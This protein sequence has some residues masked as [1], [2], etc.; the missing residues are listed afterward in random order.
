VVYWSGQRMHMKRHGGIF[1]VAAITVA[2]LAILSVLS[3]NASHPPVTG[4]IVGHCFGW[5]NPHVEIR[6][7]SSPPP[8]SQ[9]PNSNSILRDVN[10][11]GNSWFFS[12]GYPGVWATRING[13]PAD[14]NGPGGYPNPNYGVYDLR[15]DGVS[16]GNTYTYKAK[17][18]PETP[19]SNTYSVTIN[20]AN[21]G[22]APTPTPPP[23]PTPTPPPGAGTV[24]GVC[25]WVGGA[26]EVQLTWS[27]YPPPGQGAADSNALQKGDSYPSD[28]D[29]YWG[30]L[31]NN[32]SAYSYN[33]D[34][35][36][37]NT[38]YQYRVKYRS[39]LPS[40]NTYSIYVSAEN[41]GGPPPP[42]GPLVISPTFQNVPPNVTA[43]LTVSGGTG[44]YAWSAPGGTI[45]GTGSQIGVT[46]TSDSTEAVNKT[47]TV[48]SGGQT[49]TA[50]VQVDGIATLQDSINL[51][52]PGNRRIVINDDTPV[53]EYLD[54][55]LA[56]AHGFGSVAS[57]SVLV[58]LAN[59]LEGVS[60]A[61]QQQYQQSTP[62]NLC[63]A[64]GYCNE[65]PYTV[66]AIFGAP[67]VQQSGVV[68]DN[69]VYADIFDLPPSVEINGGDTVV[70]DRMVT[71]LLE[72][73]FED[74]PVDEVSMQIANRADLLDAA[75]PV[76]F[77]PT[78]SGWDLCAGLGSTCSNGTRTV[79]VKYCARGQC[80]VT[81]QDSVQLSSPWPDWG[82]R[83]N[84][85]A[86]ETG[87]A[88]V[89]LNLNPYFDRPGT[90][91]F[92]GNLA[93]LSD[94]ATRSFVA[95]VPWDLCANRVTPCAPDT[96][97][98]YVRYENDQGVFPEVESPRYEDSIVFGVAT[99]TP[100]PSITPTPLLA[101]TP[102]SST[103][104][105]P[106]DGP[107]P[108]GAPGPGTGSG[109]LPD[110]LPSGIGDL[111]RDLIA[112]L[113]QAEPVVGSIA[114]AS[115]VAVIVSAIATIVPLIG[116]GL[117]A[118]TWQS[119]MG[120][121][122][123]LP[124]RKKVWGT[125]YDA[126]TKRPIP[127]AKVQLLD[128][129]R[130]VLETRI[131]DKDGRYGF[132]TTPESLQAQNVQIAIAPNA[133]GYTFPS[134]VPPSIDTFVYNNLYYGDVI[135][136][137]EKT[138]I[139]FDVPMDPIRP[140]HAP[141]LMKSPSIALGASVALFADA[142]F[143]LGLIMVP[144]SFILN[145]N[146]FTFGT[147]C[148]FL[149]TASLRLFGISEHPFGT[150]IDGATGRPMPFAL[151][152]LNDRSGKRAAFAVSDEQGRY[153]LVVERGT[154][155]MVV[156]TPASVQPPRQSKQAVEAHKGWVTREIKL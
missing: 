101:P 110:R 113:A 126:N 132:L 145:P 10:S 124:R 1:F 47:V 92:I 20:A 133:S 3:A 72:H 40:L 8:G 48:T 58:R 9:P 146:P 96:Y 63:D 59:T 104:P 37:L 70:A 86:P 60:T 155:E 125:V 127:Y 135:T 53:T 97:A 149:G 44:T 109:G 117:A 121:M 122:G 119:F 81:V 83:I 4:Q 103:Q 61:P 140:S 115:A 150:V 26:P 116:P 68:M 130:R 52:S 32:P 84:N 152:T 131:A 134:R 28:P 128:R 51:T 7:H 23:G 94:A 136:V 35:V 76:V 19:S 89:Q 105:P 34:S 93:D 112:A 120:A 141:L 25:R 75:D 33:D 78:I 15:D 151:I 144:L 54:V 85:D 148:L 100:T 137:N 49:N 153:F 114:F 74:I 12:G 138:L 129:N 87:T 2:I 16:P 69:I 11:T 95:I 65:G 13:Q 55:N 22:G 27:Q 62:W 88:A 64:P 118:F 6:W 50:T 90:R 142:G 29:Q 143:W 57:D 108:T 31:P 154:Y 91:M 67:G 79:F 73:G 41:C 5:P 71:L 24:R 21:C 80:T 139:N 38:Q 46:Y 36:V 30:F 106:T 43:F 99:P 147:L 14:P 107:G 45:T 98:V 82:I 42:P 102:L 18:R 156:Y 123:I 17:Y 77:S 111:I 39:D 56:L 66:Y